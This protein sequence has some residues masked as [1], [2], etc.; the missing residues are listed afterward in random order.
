MI[1]AL[2][3]AL[4]EVTKEGL[5]RRWNRHQRNH[6][7]LVAGIEAMGLK[8]HV[9]P[10]FRLWSLNTVSIPEGIEDVKLRNQLLCDFD[11]EIGGGLGELKGKVW[12]VGLMGETSRA[13]NVLYFLHALEE[14]LR[15]Q[16]Y[17]CPAGA[18][19]AAASEL[20]GRP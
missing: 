7:G 16:G 12:R 3:E 15:R 19:V 6:H 14:C 2:R 18:G 13:R 5:E 4:L 9:V 11:L 20:L 1:Y 10:E 8:M 17:G